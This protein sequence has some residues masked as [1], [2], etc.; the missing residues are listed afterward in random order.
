MFNEIPVLKEELEVQKR[1]KVILLGRF[2]DAVDSG[3]GLCS[4]GSIT[5]EPVFAAYDEW[6]DRALPAII[7]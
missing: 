7:V 6:L 1:V 2:H 4:L 5:K 3:A